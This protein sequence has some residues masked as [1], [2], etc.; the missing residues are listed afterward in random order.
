[1]EL[2]WP[3]RIR[4]IA[5][6]VVGIFLIGILCWPLAAPAEPL[7]IVY[8]QNLTG[9]GLFYLIAVSLLCGIISYFI[10]R[11]YGK[12]IGIL[13]V[14][15]GLAILSIRCGNIANIMQINADIQS[16]LS[17]YN[18]LRF[19]S[20]FW[21]LLV[22]AGFAGVFAADLIPGAKAE[23]KDKPTKTIVKANIYMNS[24]I[25]VFGSILITGICIMILAQD[26]RFSDS[27]LG[28]V[29]AQPAKGQ[30]VF[31]VTI[32]FFVAGFSSKKFL[33]VSYFWPI[34]ATAFVTSISIMA[35]VNANTLE[36]MSGLWPANFFSNPIV[37]ILPIQM[38][39]FG[40][41]GAIWGYWMAV[42]Y[43]HWRHHEQ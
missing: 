10:A 22:L 6:A 32:S 25:A 24:A 28:S 21:L 9:L 43:T 19:E 39:S 33:N 30:V 16:K 18:N 14:P 12:E 38:V 8:L 27:K 13:A 5:S 40:T 31:A 26:V 34:L 3:I 42:K 35:Y 41:L 20:F 7:G 2:T 36:Y 29:I 23:N 15:A 4:I 17:I 37:S 11:P 1:M